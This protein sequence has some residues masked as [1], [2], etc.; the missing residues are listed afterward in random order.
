MSKTFSIT[1]PSVGD[2]TFRR[3][4]LPAQLR[5]EAEALRILG[6]PAHDDGLMVTALALATIAV[7]AV[8]VPD[9]WNTDDIDPL[10]NES[11]AKVFAVVAALR[12]A[13][14]RHR[15]EATS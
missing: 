10:D 13:E 3:R 4:S 7:L 15:T 14:Q 2:F 12:E 11:V 9:G 6:G 5:I 1:V 8:T